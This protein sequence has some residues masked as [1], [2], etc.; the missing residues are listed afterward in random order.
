MHEYIEHIERPLA[1]LSEAAFFKDDRYIQN[2]LVLVFTLGARALLTRAYRED[3]GALFL[4][5]IAKC[6][7]L[8]ALF[9]T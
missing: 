3:I 4:I 5:I 9:C 7:F 6:T 8:V 1:C 2:F